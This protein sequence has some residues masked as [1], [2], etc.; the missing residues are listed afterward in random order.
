MYKFLKWVLISITT[1]LIVLFLQSII[2]FSDFNSGSIS[3]CIS[4]AF[5]C[6]FF[7]N[8]NIKEKDN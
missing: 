8:K 1:T 3:G 4:M 7:P 6:H 2:G 5:F